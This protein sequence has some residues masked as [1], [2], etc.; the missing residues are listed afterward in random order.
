MK[1]RPLYL[2]GAIAAFLAV[3]VFRRNLGVEFITFNGF[4]LFSVP[5][6]Y[7][8][9]VL[10]WF[11]LL[12]SNP[13]VGMVLLEVADL[14]NY[15]L[16]ALLFTAA[17]AALWPERKAAAGFGAFLG[18]GAFVVCV[19]SN[20]AFRMLIL[21]KQ[22]SAA[23]TDA[24]R[25]TLLA[26]GQAALAIHDPGSTSFGAGWLASLLLVLVA[27]LILSIAML[28]SAAFNRA[29]AIT[30]LIAN[31]V[32]LLF[33]P[34]LPLGP[35]VYWFPPTFSAPFRI[36]WYTLMAV[37]LFRLAKETNQWIPN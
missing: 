27:G 19:F 37:R 10:D 23:T 24:A 4:G 34:I 5:A 17:A 7:P 11:G 31:G 13:F 18:W 6:D 22:Y 1:R 26:A 32:G 12:H 14:I 2:I 16:V 29:A 3:L 15:F 30:G 36:V 25:Q 33:F 28:R 20:Q 35:N 8:G 9:D 21:S